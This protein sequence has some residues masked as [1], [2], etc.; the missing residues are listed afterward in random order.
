MVV[1]D[2]AQGTV[3]DPYN[4]PDEAGIGSNLDRRAL[5]PEPFSE[6]LG[7]VRFMT[8][9]D[10]GFVVAWSEEQPVVNEWLIELC[11]RFYERVK[12]SA[13]LVF[14]PA[15]AGVASPVPFALHGT[16]EVTRIKDTSVPFLGF[17]QVGHFLSMAA[18]G[19]VMVSIRP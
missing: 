15:L 18:V 12:V 9:G 6:S 11:R 7:Q 2:P 4:K 10:R 14:R 8:L 13:L 3:S 17:D 1:H 5:Q 16:E 19:I